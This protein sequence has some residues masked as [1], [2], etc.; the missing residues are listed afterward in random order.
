MV[1]KSNYNICCYCKP[2]ANQI[3]A[4][5]IS[6]CDSTHTYD[7]S[8]NMHSQKMKIGLCEAFFALL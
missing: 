3:T 1:A 5:A 6:Y 7:S 2:V 8:P 4:F